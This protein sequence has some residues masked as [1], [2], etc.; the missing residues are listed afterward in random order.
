MPVTLNQLG[1]F[2]TGVFDES[3]AEIVAHDPTTQRLFVVNGNTSSI[4]VLDINDPANPV[5][6]SLIDLTPFGAGANS[7]AVQDGIVAVA[8]EAINTQDPGLVVFFDVNGNLLN[9]VQVGALPD[10]LTFTPDGTRV[11]VANEGEPGDGSPLV[12]GGFEEGLAGWTPTGDA[13]LATNTFGRGPVEGDSQAFLSTATNEVI[14]LDANFNP[15][16]GGTAVPAANLPPNLVN[17]ILPNTIE[18]S[19]LT[20]TFTATAGETL[21]FSYNFLT[22][23]TVG[24]NADPNFNDYAFISIEGATEVVNEVLADTTASFN[25]ISNLDSFEQY[26]F[27]NETGFETFSYTFQTTGQFTLGVGVADVGEF[28]TVSGLLVDDFSL[29]NDPEGS[30]SVVDL[31]GGVAGA[32][33]TNLDFNAFN[34][35]EEE[36]RN[37]GVRIFPGVTVSQ[38]VEPEYI[39]VAPDGNTAFV[40]LQENNAFAVLDLT[41]NTVQ[42]ILPLGFQNYSR[43]PATLQQFEFPT[44]P[45]LGTTPGGQQIL[46]GGLSGL[47]FAGTAANG[48]LQF[49]TVPDRGPNGEP[50]DTDGDGQDERPFVLPD[51]Q[52]RVVRFELNEAT[53]A[54]ENLSEIPLVRPDGVTPITGRPNIPGVDEEPVDLNGTLLTYDELGADL[55]GI[56]IAPDGSFWMVDEYRPAIYHFS[57][58]GILIN[59][60]VPEGTAALA[61]QP[62]GTFGTESLPAEY[63]NRRP[64]RGFEA[65]ALDTDRNILY[66][67]IQTPLANPDRA[68]SDNSSVIRIVGIDPAT[69]IPVEE[70]VYLLEDADVRPGGRVDKIGDAVYAGDGKFFVLERDASTSPTAKKFI[71]E[72]DINSATNLLSPNAPTLPA[73]S[74]LEQLT[75]DQL[76]ASGIRPVNKIKIANLPSLGYQA[77]DKPE[78][79]A[80]LPDGRLAVLND[81]DFGLLDQPI[82]ID[83][84]VP[85]NPNPVPVVLGLIN[86]GE[87]N[88]LDA[89]D[90]DGVINLR[91]WPVY[92]LRQPDAIA[93]FAANGSTYYI[94]ANEGDDR[95]EDARVADLVLDPQAF[96][97]AAELQQD[98]NL[99]RL[100]V[101]TL[102]G[103]LDGDGDYDQLFAYGGR[104]FTIW[105]E[106]GNLVYDS[107]DDLE[108]RLAQ[109]LPANFNSDNTENSF[110]TRSDNKGP[111]PEGLTIGIVDGRTYAFIGL[112]RVG[113]VMVYDITEP[114]T[115]QFVEYINNRDF[116]GDPAAGT[117]GDLGPE[118]LTF[119]AAEDSPN[120]QPLLA[121]GNEVSGS[122]T[123]YGITEAA[124]PTADQILTQVGD[125]V[126]QVQGQATLLFSPEVEGGEDDP[127]NE[128]GFYT[129][130][131]AQ[132]NIGP[133]APGDTGYDQAALARSQQI[134]S[135]LTNPVGDTPTRQISFPPGALIRFYEIPASTTDAISAGQTPVDSL[136]LA[137]S[138]TLEDNTVN[139]GDTSLEFET[140]DQQFPI[141]TFFQG[142][143]PQGEIID[144]DQQNG[145]QLEA[146]Y[147][148]NSE[149]KF[150]NFFGLYII[151]DPNGGVD[152]DLD[153]VTDLLPGDA[154]YEQAAF[155][156]TVLEVNL[157]G[158]S[159]SE[160]SLTLDGGLLLAPFIIANGTP[161]TFLAE[162]PDNQ[163]LDGNGPYAYFN[164]QAANPLGIDHFRLLGDNTFGAEDIFGGGDLDYNDL[165][166][167]VEFAVV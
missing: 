55:E 22:N 40:T 141:G 160:G 1:T 150:D 112:E 35:R 87:G 106:F 138:P 143:F 45:V 47:F 97:N 33:V 89:S 2:A 70:Y 82:P 144:L 39:A 104:S 43:G 27:F 41:N 127:V 60:F 3:A 108:E 165:V 159:S 29:S 158:G 148:V 26:E 72:I 96:P 120:G 71:F 132:G 84:T 93:S 44:L 63:S 79:L 94:T 19:S 145:Q 30:I 134:F 56:V 142:F 137:T 18:G 155:G 101:S 31:A 66:S 152:V 38:D 16:A 83:G 68:T 113:G 128:Y 9:Q 81:N 92:G 15:V 109:L 131:N 74:T 162:N 111:E 25:P 146:S 115:P 48:N 163:G 36:L 122:T 8:V 49:V 156:R 42:D 73:A 76:A 23:E 61:A 95:G 77:G 164:Y 110:D 5:L 12:S 4:D 59:R 133:L 80:L 85:L 24:Q 91:N 67:F 136:S 123:L 126:F 100:T 130:D 151:N 14:G 11:L 119:I 147:A 13:V 46:L 10:M 52:A 37:R 51:Y 139:F 7:V 117:A 64:N 103:D 21:T 99:G 129:V 154:G 20:Q 53:G 153:G 34:G 54:I 140:T 32:T 121:V 86:F 98:A 102:D 125:N 57:T 65:I 116:S 166:F 107:G 157:G 6:L 69:G 161:D 90:A 149:A 62:V 105:D 58:D 17:V 114:T 118:G 124:Q 135:V 28:T 88:T 78:G 167:Q 50:T 75:P